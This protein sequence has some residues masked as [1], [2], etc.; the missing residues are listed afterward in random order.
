MSFRGVCAQSLQ[1]LDSAV[2]AVETAELRRLERR[3]ELEAYLLEMQA[4]SRRSGG[5]SLMKPEIQEL[6]QQTEHWLLDTENA[7]E[8][9]FAA[10]LQRVKETLQRECSDFFAA[11]AAE[12][13][14]QE[15]ELEAAA[16]ATAAANVKE[17]MDVK[18]PNSQCIKRAKKNKEEANELFRG[19][20]YTCMY[21]PNANALLLPQPNP[22]PQFYILA[23]P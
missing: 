17:D 14:K 8:E 1:Q 19:E 21:T 7:T 5:S 12:R 6:L 18:L 2:G 3:N 9:E 11:A 16:A 15:T 13:Q 22:K 4:A 10:A 20:L 23:G